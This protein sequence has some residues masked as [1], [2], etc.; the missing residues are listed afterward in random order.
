MNIPDSLIPD[1][2][3]YWAWPDN[4]VSDQFY[5]QGAKYLY[6]ITEY[7]IFDIKL[8][9]IWLKRIEYPV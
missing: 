2:W 8:C 6:E 1:I 4:E 5:S 9:D 7:G 3:Q